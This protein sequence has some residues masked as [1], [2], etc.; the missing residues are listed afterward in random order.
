MPSWV[1]VRPKSFCIDGRRS[2]KIDAV[3]IENK[4]HKAD[5]KKDQA[6]GLLAHYYHSVLPS[7][8]SYFVCLQPASKVMLSDTP[9]RRVLWDQDTG[10]RRRR[11]IYYL[12]QEHSEHL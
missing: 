7:I 2:R 9:S 1:A 5:G 6:T 11:E 4:I 3:D 8:F 12:H 10:C